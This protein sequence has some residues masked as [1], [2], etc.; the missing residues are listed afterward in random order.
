M[1][2]TE[3]IDYIVLIIMWTHAWIFAYSEA[4]QKGKSLNKHCNKKIK[5]LDKIFKSF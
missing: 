5:Q 3:L 2:K 1:T 4:L